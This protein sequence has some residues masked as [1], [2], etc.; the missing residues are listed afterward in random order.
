MLSRMASERTVTVRGTATIRVVPDEAQLELSLFKVD[1]RSEDAHADVATRAQ[2]LEALLDELEIPAADRTTTGVSVAPESEWTGS[3]WQRKG[4]RSSMR[5]VVRVHDPAT[6]GRLI[7][8]AVDRV[9]ATVRG[10]WWSLSPNHPSRVDA[11]TAAAEEARRRAEA[12]VR[13]LGLAAGDVVE[14]REPGVGRASGDLDVF[15]HPVAAPPAFSLM[16]DRAGD[17]RPPPPEVNVEPGEVEVSGAVE[18]TFALAP[19]SS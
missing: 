16:A 12:Y 18:V 11:C 5:T 10:P 14:I 2:Q 6:V 3:R 1:R 9:E 4:W 19:S 15:T 17:Q 13:G 8:E 7:A